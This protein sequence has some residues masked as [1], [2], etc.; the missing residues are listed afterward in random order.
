MVI[1]EDL[2]QKMCCR[3]TS[4]RFRELERTEEEM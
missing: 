4:V 2:N 3:E 1:G